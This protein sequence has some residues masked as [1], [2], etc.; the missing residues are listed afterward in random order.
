[1]V[2]CRLYYLNV[3]ACFTLTP[4]YHGSSGIS[5]GSVCFFLLTAAENRCFH[6][7]ESAAE[8]TAMLELFLEVK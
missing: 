7:L 5:T 3:E 6:A 8:F 2:V 4:E 1:M